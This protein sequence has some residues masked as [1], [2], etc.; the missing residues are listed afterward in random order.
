MTALDRLRFPVVQVSLDLTSIEE[1]LDTAAIAV[2]AGV[3]WLE[4][5]TPLLLAEGLRAVEKL[6]ERFP[7]HPVVADCTAGREIWGGLRP[8]GSGGVVIAAP[9]HIDSGYTLTVSALPRRYP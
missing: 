2:E 8:G 9:T 5:G 3:D 4:A 1:A 7:D 6:H